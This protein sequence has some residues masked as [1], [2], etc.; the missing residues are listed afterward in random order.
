VHGADILILA[1][2]PFAA[3]DVVVEV[4]DLIDYSRQILLSVVAG[5][6]CDDFDEYLF[7]DKP[8]KSKPNPILFRVMP[9]IAI[10][11][12]E[13]MTF[14]SPRNANS[15]Q[16]KLAESM[17]N[18]MG[19][20]M[21]VPESLLAAAMAV[22]SCGI[23]YVMR[24]VRA[25]ISGAVEAGFSADDAYKIVL[26]TMKGA[27]KLL[28]ENGQHPEVEI[29]RVVTPGGFTIRG[30][31]AMEANGF[32]SAVVAGIRESYKNSK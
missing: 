18:E 19:Q 5:V 11:I 7:G 4:R 20:T 28:M 31:N 27:I 6:S 26:Q 21:V 23:A 8:G 29:D 14:I 1:V 15:A 3:K 12:G 25:S 10:S 32:S 30:L 24:Y 22:G 16:K 17:F 13:S 2:K 9:N